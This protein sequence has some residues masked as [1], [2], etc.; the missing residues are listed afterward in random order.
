M[1][2]QDA[3]KR[4]VV[5]RFRATLLLVAFDHLEFLKKYVNWKGGGETNSQRREMIRKEMKILADQLAPYF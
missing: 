5:A 4:D 1:Q 2:A 3:A